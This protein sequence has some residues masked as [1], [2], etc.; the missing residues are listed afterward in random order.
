LE[1]L[2]GGEVRWEWWGEAEE[3]AGDVT[4][5]VTVT[6]RE[7]L[8]GVVK[9][10]HKTLVVDETTKERMSPTI[11]TALPRA[12]EPS[13]ALERSYESAFASQPVM[14]IRTPSSIS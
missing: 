11:R 5:T 10:P 13:C 9:A 7:Y 6:E 8:A 1:K 4:V 2:E 12:I 14:K 3:R